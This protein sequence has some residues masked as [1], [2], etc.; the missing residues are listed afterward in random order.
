MLSAAR[1][2]QSDRK[3]MSI[4]GAD[5]VTIPER[6]AGEQA[7]LVPGV[8]GGDG[9]LFRDPYLRGGVI[10]LRPRRRIQGGDAIRKR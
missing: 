2:R 9:G 1:D 7:I 4:I 5:Q 10:L 8:P 3:T 6:S